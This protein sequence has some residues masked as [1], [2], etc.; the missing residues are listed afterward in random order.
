MYLFILTSDHWFCNQTTYLLWFGDN[1]AMSDLCILIKTCLD[2]KEQKLIVRF[3]L[4]LLLLQVKNDLFCMHEPFCKSLSEKRQFHQIYSRPRMLWR[5][6]FSFVCPLT[7][8]L[9]HIAYN[10]CQIVSQR[11]SEQLDYTS[12]SLDSLS[13]L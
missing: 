10:C 8:S 3:L 9:I 1:F 5:G 6:K 7:Y 12:H 13:S 2:T 11:A 4:F